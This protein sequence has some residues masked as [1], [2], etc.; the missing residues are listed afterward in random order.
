MS[1]LRVDSK[2]AYPRLKHGLRKSRH[3][4]R[5]MAM[6]TPE[7]A[8]SQKVKAFFEVD[9]ER[10]LGRGRHLGNEISN[11]VRVEESTRRPD[12]ITHH[13]GIHVQY[14]CVLCVVY[15]RTVLYISRGIPFGWRPNGISIENYACVHIL[16]SSVLS[17]I[18]KH[19]K[20]FTQILDSYRV[21]WG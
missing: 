16:L 10:V 3:G 9:H 14:C 19:Q 11:W 5:K 2:R 17:W 7:G 21:Y 4:E 13:L 12:L 8:S 20:W 15:F 1:A 6:S 18:A